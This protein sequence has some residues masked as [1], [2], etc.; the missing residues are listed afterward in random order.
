MN[1]EDAEEFTQSLGQIVG[2][3]WRQIVLAKRL[4]VPQALGLDVDE[5]VN[6]RLGGYV[7]MTVEDRRKAVAE[8][9]AEGNSVRAIADIVGVRS[10][11]V[12]R[13]LNVPNGTKKGDLDGETVP[14]GTAPLDAVAALAVT[15]DDDLRDARQSKRVQAANILKDA[16]PVDCENIIVGDFRDFAIRIP[17]D[18]VDLVFTDPPYDRDSIS[19]YDAAAKEASRIL[20]PGGSFIAYGGQYLLP[21]IL[22]GCGRHLRLWWVNACLHGGQLARMTEYGI[23]VHWKP[24]VW[25][26]KGSRGDKETFVDDAIGGDREKQWHPWQQSEKQAAYYIEKLTHADGLVVDFFLGGGT[27]AIAAESL[28]RRWIG[29][30]K[31]VTHAANSADR[32]AKFRAE[33]A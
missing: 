5:W 10:S 3:S 21:E 26:V 1:R 25:F 18:S 4:G 27:T 31:D 15:A 2:G 11:T 29:F 9:A 14:N 33:V 12:H 19:L 22:A 6:Q 23:V 30:E 16:K 13:D 7:R 28:R 8:L 32:V 24:M 20:K 17:D